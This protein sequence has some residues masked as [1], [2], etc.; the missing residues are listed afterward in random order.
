MKRNVLYVVCLTILTLTISSCRSSAPSYDYKALAKA[1]LKLGF[2]ISQD[3]NHKLYIEASRWI[4]VPYRAGGES[5][6]GVDCSGL[7][8][9]IYSKVYNRRLP[10][11]S[12][13]QYNLVRRVPKRK[14]EEGDLVFFSTDGRRKRVSHVGVYLKNGKFIHSSTSSG[15]IISSLSERYY[16]NNWIYGGRIK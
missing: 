7:T 16:Q 10:R 12:A 6:N 3:D 15:V 5:K 9:S 11:S 14:L 13:E 1:S 8:K 4:G 2:D